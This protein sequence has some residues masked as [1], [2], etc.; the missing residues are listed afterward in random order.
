MPFSEKTLDFLFENRLQDSKDWFDAHKNIY[1][2]HVLEPLQELVVGLSDA[3]LDLDPLVTIDPKVGK[4]ISRIRRDTR[5]TK[6]KRIYRE[7]M[8]IVFK[9][10]PRMYGTDAPGIYF[11][12]SPDNFGYGCGYYYTD[13]E[14]MDA[15]RAAILAGSPEAMAAIDAYEA[16]NIFTLDGDRY[17]RPRYP[18]Q[19]E[20]LRKWLE[21]RNISLSAESTDAALLFSDKLAE[22][23]SA[24]F[25]VLKPMYRFLLKIA[26][27]VYGGTGI[28]DEI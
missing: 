9:R 26:I 16:Q 11:E 21:L 4:T 8:W 12:M 18:D 13:P 14:Y 28:E 10:G 1:Q 6:D 15:L 19:P 7:H 25:K 24:D 5:F 3:A 22:K 27:Q 17:K 2:E 23:V 20:K